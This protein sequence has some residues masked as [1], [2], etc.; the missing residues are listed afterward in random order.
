MIG[1]N[2]ISQT[3]AD[4]ND[5][6]KPWISRLVDEQNQIFV[7]QFSLGH[8]R[9]NENSSDEYESSDEECCDLRMVQITYLMILKLNFS[10]N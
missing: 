1:L 10:N 8:L 2:Q 7:D 4:T 9:H 3:Y 6:I 5:E